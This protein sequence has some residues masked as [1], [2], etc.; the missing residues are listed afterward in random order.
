MQYV[1]QYAVLYDSIISNYSLLDFVHHLMF[2]TK[3]KTDSK[4]LSDL[5]F[6]YLHI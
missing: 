3:V 1:Q 5:I 4:I 2:N 6:Y